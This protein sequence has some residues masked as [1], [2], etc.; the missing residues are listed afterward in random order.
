MIIDT[1]RT[2]LT[3]EFIEAHL[4][5]RIEQKDERVDRFIMI[6]KEHRI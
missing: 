4:L 5:R 6:D 2:R 1:S 3:D